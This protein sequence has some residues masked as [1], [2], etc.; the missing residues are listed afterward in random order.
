[1]TFKTFLIND[2]RNSKGWQ[3]PRDIILA[4]AQKWIGVYGIAH[5]AC[6]TCDFE[7]SA[8]QTLEEA[9]Q[10]SKEDAVTVIVDVSWDNATSTLYAE[11][12]ILKK[13]FE[14]VLCGPIYAVSPSIW[15]HNPKEDIVTDYEPVHLAF[16]D[17]DGAYGP[18]SEELEK[19]CVCKTNKQDTC[20]SNM[21]PEKKE[22]EEK[23]EMSSEEMTKQMYAMMKEM[24]GSMKKAMDKEEPEEKPKDAPEQKKASASKK[25]F[26]WVVN[27]PSTPKETVLENTPLF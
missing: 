21:D 19:S 25:S 7:H 5:K 17:I 14:A 16:L 22:P 10:V 6:S 15:N 1:M 23:Q 4:T 20:N 18:S 2:K 9:L 8:G 12:D 24:H 11:H 26:D 3:I 13:E 27:Q